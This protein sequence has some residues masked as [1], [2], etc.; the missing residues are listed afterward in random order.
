MY[1][2]LTGELPLGHFQ[3]PSRRVGSDPSIDD[4]VL[5]AMERDRRHRY[6]NVRDLKQRLA[7]A[8]TDPKQPIS[9]PARPTSETGARQ[10]RF[11]ELVLSGSSLTAAFA[12]MIAILLGVVVAIDLPK[13]INPSPDG[14]HQPQAHAAIPPSF[15]LAAGIVALCLSFLFARINVST[16]SRWRDLR[17]TQYPSL[18]ALIFGYVLFGMLLLTGPGIAALLLGAMPLITNEK[19]R[20]FLGK[21]FTDNDRASFLSPY[22]LT[23]YGLTLLT[24]AA[25]CIL[26]AI[27]LRKH[28]GLVR[29]FFHPSTEEQNS[30]IVRMVAL[31]AVTIFIPLGLV[32]LLR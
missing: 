2:I 20:S 3:P 14:L 9:R 15:L 21:V 4:V 6:Q 5:R 10:L 31:S 28:P 17:W 32:L 1:E 24:A 16:I 23:T 27:V 7:S 8:R 30:V 13:S 11:W 19:N 25:W 29:G 18:P 22:W 12:G 26:F